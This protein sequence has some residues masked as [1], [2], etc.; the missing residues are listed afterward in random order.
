[1]TATRPDADAAER[2][3]LRDCVAQQNLRNKRNRHIEALEKQVKLCQELHRSRSDH[4]SQN[5]EDNLKTIRDL[6]AENAA[7]RERQKHR[8]SLF[9]S[10]KDVFE[11]AS[12]AAATPPPAPEATP[13]TYVPIVPQEVSTNESQTPKPTPTQTLQPLQPLQSHTTHPEEATVPPTSLPLPP[14]Q[15]A[16]PSP[17]SSASTT[18]VVVSASVPPYY[19]Y[20]KAGQDMETLPDYSIWLAGISANGSSTDDESEAE[21]M[22]HLEHNHNL[23]VDDGRI[24]GLG[25]HSIAQSYAM[26][27]PAIPLHATTPSLFDTHHSQFTA[28]AGVADMWASRMPAPLSTSIQATSADLTANYTSTI[29]TSKPFMYSARQPVAG[30]AQTTAPPDGGLKLWT[31]PSGTATSSTGTGTGVDEIPVWARIPV[32]TSGPNDVRRPAWDANMRIIFDS[33]EVPAPLDI[34]FGSHQNPLASSLQRSIKTY[35]Q[36]NPE[37]LAIGWLVYHYI[38]WRTQPSAERYALLPQFLKPIF[39]QIW[40]PHPGSI[41]LI[42]WE[43]LRL[44]LL[45]TYDRYDMVKFIR[46][47]CRCLRLRWRW[48]EDVL[49]T[50][51]EGTHVLRPDFV[52]RFMSAAGWGLKPEFVTYYPELFDGDKWDQ[53][54][55]NPGTR[56]IV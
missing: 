36:G 49:V 50:N 17:V 39:E 25:N 40:V 53:I 5:D 55:Y 38:K 2:K 31:A 56:H 26:Q 30:E 21:A 6:R 3:R 24:G 43:G 29:A 22:H 42:I 51:A 52:E 7:L 45:K 12:Q 9:Q 16:A 47:Y 33:P 37:R 1:M 54:V 41:D 35:Y 19:N 34:V 46:T 10:F 18:E 32:G 11:P 28:T 20:N 44:K 4:S 15:N 14:P 48:D 8:Q 27:A 23:Q 13:T